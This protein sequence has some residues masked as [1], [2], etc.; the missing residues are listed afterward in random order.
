MANQSYKVSVYVL[1][2]YILNYERIL[3][4]QAKRKKAHGH[5]QQCS[6]CRLDGRDVRR[7]NN[8]AKNKIK[9]NFKII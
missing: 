6:D 1:L 3:E 9:I 5:E 8:N 2:N 4:N 7:I